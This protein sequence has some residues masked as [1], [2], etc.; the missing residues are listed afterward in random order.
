MNFQPV[1]DKSLSMEAVI[2]CGYV[3]FYP[4]WRISLLGDSMCIAW[5]ESLDQ[6]VT[7]LSPLLVLAYLRNSSLWTRCGL[8]DV[9]RRPAP[10]LKEDKTKAAGDSVAVN[11]WID[12][13]KQSSGQSRN[14]ELYLNFIFKASTNT[15]LFVF[16]DG[17]SWVVLFPKAPSRQTTR[18]SFAYPASVCR[19][20]RPSSRVNVLKI[21]F[22]VRKLKSIF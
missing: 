14:S 8:N 21:F 2:P 18:H 11:R 13:C 10:M 20:Y 1:L 9:M 3:L 17:E 19:I 12:P 15:S 16:L 5:N 22:L 7:L 6:F 4:C